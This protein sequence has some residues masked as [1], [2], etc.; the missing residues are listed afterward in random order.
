[1]VTVQEE[2]GKNETQEVPSELQETLFFY[3]EG[4]QALSQVVQ[5]GGVPIIGD[6]QEP[7]QCDPGQQVLGDPA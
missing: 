4:D 6:I 3:C 2:M 5:K 7:S 1:M